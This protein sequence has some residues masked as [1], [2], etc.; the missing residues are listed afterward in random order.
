MQSLKKECTIGG[1]RTKPIVRN[2]CSI[3]HMCKCSV[4]DG[5]I[6]LLQAKKTFITTMGDTTEIQ[7]IILKP[8]RRKKQSR[9][10]KNEA[11]KKSQRIAAARGVPQLT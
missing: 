7:R 11:K 1:L 2:G 5:Q 6:P 4:D 8:S 10:G 3:L 9:E